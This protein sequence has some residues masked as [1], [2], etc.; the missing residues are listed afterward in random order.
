MNEDKASVALR[1]SIRSVIGANAGDPQSLRNMNVT[2]YPDGALCFVNENRTL[3]ELNKESTATP[4]NVTVVAAQP[5]GQGNWLILNGSPGVASLAEIVGTAANSVTTGGTT[6]VP[7]TG[8]AF[9]FQPAGAPAGWTL[10]AA[11]GILT[12]HGTQPA[13]VLAR[14]I[15][16]IEVTA[17]STGQVWAAITQNGADIGAAPATSFLIGTQESGAGGT[18]FPDVIATERTLVLAPGDT[19]QAVLGTTAGANLNLVRGTLSVLIP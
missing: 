6:F 11:G 13:R 2:I 9:A 10:T 8:S 1:F 16:S 7:I 19:L 4:D 5:A 3:Y 14:F 12:Y 18:G 17:E 15:G